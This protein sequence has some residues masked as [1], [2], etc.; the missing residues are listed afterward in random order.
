MT[1]S[2]RDKERSRTPGLSLIASEGGS[3]HE[4]LLSLPEVL[5]CN[6]YACMRVIAMRCNCRFR[7]RCQDVA[8]RYVYN[9]QP[10]SRPVVS[11]GVSQRAHPQYL[12]M[13]SRR[14]LTGAKWNCLFLHICCVVPTCVHYL[15]M[16]AGQ[17]S[18]TNMC[19]GA[20]IIQIG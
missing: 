6:G 5:L 12:D 13:N 10:Y 20:L 1:W 9:W 19:A 15:I 7:C 11:L 16:H 4:L 8:G 3:L 17:F 2:D 14:S 18:G